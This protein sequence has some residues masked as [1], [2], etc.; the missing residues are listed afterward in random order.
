MLETG[1]KSAR[2]SAAKSKLG[3][4]SIIHPR[5]ARTT[6]VSQNCYGA[7]LP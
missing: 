6:A 1:R 4:G 3:E 5:F 7:K 2:A